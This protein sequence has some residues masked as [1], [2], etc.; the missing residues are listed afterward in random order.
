MQNATAAI[1]SIAIRQPTT[2]S[3]RT[4]RTRRSPPGSAHSGSMSSARH[5][6]CWPPVLIAGRLRA[7]SAAG[8]P[9]VDRLGGHRVRDVEALNDVAAQ[10]HERGERQTV[11]D[12][13]G[14]DGQPEADGFG[15]RPGRVERADPSGG[16]E[17]EAVESG[18]SAP[19]H[20]DQVH[21]E[22]RVGPANGGQADPHHAGRSTDLVRRYRQ[23]GR[24]EVAKAADDGADQR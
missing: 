24:A 18:S 11:L 7:G 12:R 23:S 13:L 15:P 21:G 14:H 19:L 2:A 8:P 5:R 3:G 9:R 10:G 1:G 22:R 6:T 16:R 20:A 4:G 17:P